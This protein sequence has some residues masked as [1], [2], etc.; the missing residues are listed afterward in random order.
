VEPWLLW[1]WE[2]KDES[3]R[4]AVNAVEAFASKFQQIGVHGVKGT[5]ASRNS[6]QEGAVEYAKSKHIGL[7]RP[8]AD[9]SRSR[10]LEAVRTVSDASVLF[11]L[12]H[13]DTRTW[14]SMTYG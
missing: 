10:R 13:P 4:G 8:L 5:M 12:C 14:C 7:L 6:F 1:I 2:C 11:G 3:R 9:G